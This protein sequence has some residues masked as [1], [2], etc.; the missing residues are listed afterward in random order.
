[1]QL[2]SFQKFVLITAVILFLGTLIIVGYL[3]SQIK[4][5]ITDTPANCPNFWIDTKGDGTACANPHKLG[6]CGSGPIDFSG[7]TLCEKYKKALGCK[8]TWDLITDNP[9]L[10]ES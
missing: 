7:F 4:P 3:M 1:M 8:L 2:S 10:C 6:T 9:S 5:S